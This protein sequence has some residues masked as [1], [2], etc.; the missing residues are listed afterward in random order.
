MEKVIQLLITNLVKWVPAG[1]GLSV[2]AHALL[3]GE[4]MHAILLSFATAC[5]SIWVKFSS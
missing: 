2:T 1:V 4:W 5:S 3:A